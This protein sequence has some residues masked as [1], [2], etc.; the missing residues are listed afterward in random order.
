MI[1]AVVAEV[2]CCVLWLA[3]W[4]SMCDVL[5]WNRGANV[6]G[7]LVLGIVEWYV[8]L[9]FC[10]GGGVEGGGNG[11]GTLDALRKSDIW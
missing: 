2:T 11:G 9:S 10:A 1:G 8:F 6:V 3:S 5:R 7:L 4:A